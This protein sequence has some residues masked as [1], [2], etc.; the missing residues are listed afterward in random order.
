LKK[1][2]KKNVNEAER[3]K[4]LVIDDSQDFREFLSELIGFYSAGADVILA[5]N[6]VE[7]LRIFS[8]NPASFDVVF[9]DRR[10]PGMLG[11][12]VVREIKKISS[13]TRVV[14]MSGDDSKEVLRVAKAAGADEVLFKLFRNEEI[15]RI[16]SF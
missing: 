2:I 7:G 15:K 4:V 14:F 16:L 11:E 5:E 8:N 3:M 6:G 9:T 10:M 13:Q 1:I 12:E